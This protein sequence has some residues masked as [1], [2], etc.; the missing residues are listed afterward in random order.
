MKEVLEFIENQWIKKP[1]I[2]KDEMIQ[3][4]Y[5]RFKDL[6]VKPLP[7]E[8]KKLSAREIM[9]IFN[10]EPGPLVGK[11]LKFV[12]DKLAQNPSLTRDELI[13]LIREEF[14]L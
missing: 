13:K 1:D 4:L 10:L 5:S 8:E 11:V 7:Q 3:R 6:F 12:N 2:T 14:N 9:E